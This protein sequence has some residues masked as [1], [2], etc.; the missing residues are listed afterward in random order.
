MKVFSAPSKWKINSKACWLFLFMALL[1]T[2]LL[3]PQP[4]LA[5]ERQIDLT[6]RL[7]SRGSYN[8]VIAGKA[9]SFYLEISNIGNKAITD[10]KLSSDKPD[11]WVIDFTTGKI[12]YL[13][14][15][16]LQT[17][18]VNIKPPEN[19]SGGE[20]GVN[21]IAEAN[22]TRKVEKFW[23]TVKTTSVKTTSVWLWI[24]VGVVLAAIIA[25]VF[26][27]RRF[28]RQKSGT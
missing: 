16:S 17:I 5:Q 24:G 10:I 1:M 26:I 2:T 3:L 12:D 27:Y 18:D 8:E 4:A 25:F 6:L 22:E 13:G 11:G 19:V 21:I 23:V 9:N 7:F 28:G 15:G 20:Y 14:P